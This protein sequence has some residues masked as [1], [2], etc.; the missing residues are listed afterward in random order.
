MN[1]GGNISV[2][3]DVHFFFGAGFLE[4]ASPTQI[5]IRKHGQNTEHRKTKQSSDIKNRSK[6]HHSEVGGKTTFLNRKPP[7]FLM[8]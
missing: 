5:S 6:I 4:G 7:N 1:V 8:T 3:R 2:M